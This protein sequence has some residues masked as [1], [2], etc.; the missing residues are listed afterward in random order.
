[1]AVVLGKSDDYNDI[2]T[3]SS[4]HNKLRIKTSSSSLL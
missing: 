2:F 1:M 4:Q 3:E